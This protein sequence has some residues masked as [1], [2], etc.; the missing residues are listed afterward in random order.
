MFRWPQKHEGGERSERDLTLLSGLK[1]CSEGR[2]NDGPSGREG[3]GSR[4]GGGQRTESPRRQ[5]ECRKMVLPSS[6]GMTSGRA[7]GF[8]IGPLKRKRGRN[9]WSFNHGSGCRASGRGCL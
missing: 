2:R 3:K 9:I 7:R 8:R 1:F 4:G 5:K 6:A